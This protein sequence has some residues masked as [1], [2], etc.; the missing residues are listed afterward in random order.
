MDDLLTVKERLELFLPLLGVVVL[1]ALVGQ[2][3]TVVCDLTCLD[4]LFED[5]LKLLQKARAREFGRLVR[6]IALGWRR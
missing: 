4:I 6:N 1:Q 5:Q 2:R 3:V